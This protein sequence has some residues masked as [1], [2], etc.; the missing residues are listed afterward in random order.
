MASTAISRRRCRVRMPFP[1][2]RTTTTPVSY[3][4]CCI[5]VETRT[6]TISTMSQTE[7]GSTTCRSEPG[8]WLSS[9]RSRALMPPPSGEVPH[10]CCLR[11]CSGGR[12]QPVWRPV[13]RG[14]THEPG[15]RDLA[16]L[17]PLVAA[18]TAAG[19]HAAISCATHSLMRRSSVGSGMR[20]EP[21]TVSWNALMSK[22][23]PRAASASARIRWISIRPIM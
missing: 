22:R 23:S 19:D 10:R 16:A 7:I 18:S 5:W 21:S 17:T 6:S 1:S 20:P 8:S 13:R 9:T 15:R 2:R 12:I 14:S 11:A 4:K 3:R